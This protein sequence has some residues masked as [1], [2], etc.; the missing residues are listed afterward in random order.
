MIIGIAT[1]LNVTDP[2]RI[3]KD[4]VNSLYKQLIAKTK[5][6]L[7]AFTISDI[8]RSAEGNRIPT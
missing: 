6:F 8:Q 3:R 7:E 4:C 5:S 1:L 2:I